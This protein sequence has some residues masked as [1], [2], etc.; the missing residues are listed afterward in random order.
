MGAGNSEDHYIQDA[1][2]VY[3]VWRLQTL[4][5]KNGTAITDD[6]AEKLDKF[7][8]Y[9]DERNIYQKF[10]DSVYKK[11]VDAVVDNFF[12]DLIAKYPGRKFDVVDV[13]KKFRDLNRK[14]DFAL[15]FSENEYVS[16]SLKNYK[17]GYDS[18]QLCSGTWNSFLNNFLFEPDGVGMFI[19]P[20]TE[21]RFKGS[22]RTVRD[23][24]IDSMGLSPLKDIYR[25]FDNILDEVRV[26]YVESE[27]AKMFQNVKV[28]WKNDCVTYGQNAA[29]SVVDALNCLDRNKV[30]QRIIKMAGLN[31]DEEILLVG[32][33]NYLCSLF[34]K[35]YIN[36]LKRV[37]SDDCVVEYNTKGQGV[38]FILRDSDG[39]IVDIGVPFTLQKNGAWYIPKEE[40][41]GTEYHPKE[42][43]D[44]AYGERR[45]NKSKEI[46]TST[47]TFL[48]LKEA[49]S[50]QIPTVFVNAI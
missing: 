1:A 14:G 11:N 22:N 9:C 45:P 41:S 8:T 6:V 19:N 48:K 23:Q 38:S 5:V 32:R 15:Y 24:L 36:I 10:C 2:E 50:L 20:L 27:E 12:R 34:D 4:A 29:Q 17:N 16:F 47:N 37:S 46:S 21:E 43:V 39:I 40:Y 18:I 44:L 7:E 35:R 31:Y 28:R 42:K 26:F 3:I 13:E 33:G 30:K 25:I 49:L